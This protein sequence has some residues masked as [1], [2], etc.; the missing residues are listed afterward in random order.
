MTK[1]GKEEGEEAQR[2]MAWS[3]FR[4]RNERLSGG[5]L[6]RFGDVTLCVAG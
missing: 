1:K 3:C 2:P 6:V 5:S 4:G